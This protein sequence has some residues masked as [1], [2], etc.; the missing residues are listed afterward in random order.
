LASRRQPA[1]HVDCDVFSDVQG[2][3]TFGKG[4]Y[5]FELL[6]QQVRLAYGIFFLQSHVYFYID[7]VKKQQ[8]KIKLISTCN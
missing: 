1:R 6:Y 7:V 2:D 5:V 3:V 8:V 4:T